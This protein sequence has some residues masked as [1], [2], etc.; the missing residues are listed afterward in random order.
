MCEND[1]TD[2][3]SSDPKLEAQ[4]QRLPSVVAADLL[5][6]LEGVEL[7]SS[8]KVNLQHQPPTIANASHT[9]TYLLLF[10]FFPVSDGLLCSVS[11]PNER[12][13]ENEEHRRR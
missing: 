10:C 6:S 9:L 13:G 2:S 1:Q 12:F 3:L 11:L 7:G 8:G 5:P 4:R